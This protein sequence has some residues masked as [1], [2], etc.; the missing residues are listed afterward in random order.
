[1]KRFAKHHGFTMIELL[2]V[3]FIV[4]I[5][6]MVAVN[7]YRTFGMKSK[8][9]DGINAILNLQL[10]EE[11][12]RSNNTTYG[13]LAQLSGSATSPQGYYSLAISNV[14]AT[15]FTITATGQGNQAN[16]NESGTA[17]SPLVLAVSGTTVTQT[18]TSC[19]PS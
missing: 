8:R 1:M 9:A 7:T 5:I 10:A 19:W 3:I 17:C 14:T 4:A 6:S 16:D 15:T 11:R 12:Y 18:P 2:V 13:T